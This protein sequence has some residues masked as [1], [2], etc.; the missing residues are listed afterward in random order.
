MYGSRSHHD[1]GLGD[2][3]LLPH[4]FLLV[5]HDVRGELVPLLLYVPLPLVV[6]E[7]RVDAHEGLDLLRLAVVLQVAAGLHRDVLP[8]LATQAVSGEALLAQVGKH[9][10]EEKQLVFALLQVFC[11]TYQWGF[12]DQRRN[13]V[14]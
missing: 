9:W 10:E 4:E 8:A 11:G 1:V 12:T 3:G 13:A 2:R 14:L 5:P 6:A 7:D